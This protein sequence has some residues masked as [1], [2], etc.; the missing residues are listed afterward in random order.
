M[1]NPKGVGRAVRRREG[2]RYGRLTAVRQVG[3]NDH[4]QALWECRC[5]CGNVVVKSVVLLNRG[6]KQ[7]RKRCPMGVHVKHGATTHATRSKEYTVWA[8]MKQRCINP[9]S[10]KYKYYGGRGIT[11]CQEWVDSFDAFL[12]HIGYAPKG[13]RISIDRVDNNGNYEP[14]NVRWATPYQQVMN[15]RNNKLSRM[16]TTTGE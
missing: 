8:S 14:G 12:A 3:V 15:R 10:Q 2:E 4:A 9:S 7:C 13:N 6:A 11:V 16:I 1:G 5:D